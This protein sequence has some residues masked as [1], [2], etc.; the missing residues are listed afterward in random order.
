MPRNF[1]LKRFR[2]GLTIVAVVIIVAAI[3]VAIPGFMQPRF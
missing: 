3:L 2:L 1:L